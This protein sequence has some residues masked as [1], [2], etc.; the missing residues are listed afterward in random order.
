MKEK[1]EFLEVRFLGYVRTHKLYD[2]NTPN[3]DEP[4]NPSKNAEAYGEMVQFLDDKS[5]SRII[6]DEWLQKS[7]E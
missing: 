4:V 6:R 3:M 2:T 1:Y 7:S 5:L